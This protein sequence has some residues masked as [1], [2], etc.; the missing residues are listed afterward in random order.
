MT[1]VYHE[2]ELSVQERV[3]VQDIAQRNSKVIS[4]TIIK[5][6]FRFIEQQQ[7]AVIGS[8]DRYDNVWASVITGMPGFMETLDGKSVNFD[9]S[10]TIVN[11]V[12]PLWKNIENNPQVG[13]LIIELASRRRLRING[14]ISKSAN[15]MQLM[16]QEAYPNCPKYIQRRN[17]IA[18]PNPQSIKETTL[19]NGKILSKN[20]RQIIEKADS[21]FVASI[22]KKRGVDASHRGG[23]P[24]FVKIINDSTIRIPDY[25]GNSMF[26]TLGNFIITPKAGLIFVDFETNTTLQ[27]IGRPE[28]LWVE[29]DPNDESGGTKRFWD[30][31]IEEF[32]Q[33]EMGHQLKWSFE[34]YS[35]FNPK[36]N[37][38]Q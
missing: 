24:G 27:L 31:R 9:L 15:A 19:I 28:I 3:G 6:A 22:H 37:I 10:K 18:N 1:N 13:M 12:D 20:Q 26:N 2:G 25:L 7:M 30:L 5:G 21:F 16:V 38:K 36:S 33:I 14:T 32:R 17:I 4:N 34:D 23:N 29:E 35:P 11:F 8:V